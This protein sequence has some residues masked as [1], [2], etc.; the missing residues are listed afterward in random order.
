[1]VI[2]LKNFFLENKLVDWLTYLE[3]YLKIIDKEN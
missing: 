1:M 3:N 2:F